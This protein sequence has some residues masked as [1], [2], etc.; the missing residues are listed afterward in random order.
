MFRRPWIWCGGAVVFA[1]F[2]PNILWEAQHAW[3]TIQLLQTVA[4]VKNSHITAWDFLWQQ[5]LLTNPIAAP[6]WFAGLWYFFRHRTGRT[7]TV[8]GFAYLTVL[9]ELLLLHGTLYYL[10]PAYPI[11][12]ASR[13][14]WIQHEILPLLS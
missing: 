8:L 4:I 11:L 2:L 3:P 1:I 14:V 10:A 6:I 5:T 7:Y 12:F 13:S 9:I